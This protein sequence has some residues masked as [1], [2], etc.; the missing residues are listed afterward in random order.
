METRYGKPPEKP[1]DACCV[2]APPGW[3]CHCRRAAKRATSEPNGVPRS[4]R[5]QKQRTSDEGATT[6]RALGPEESG[7]QPVTLERRPEVPRE[8]A[9][10]AA[11][12]RPVVQNG[13]SAVST[14]VKPSRRYALT[15]LL[16]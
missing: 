3:M 14:R 2:D 9:R 15:S 12:G 10:R 13:M 6:K 7:L 5:D 16:S 1:L 8:S 11:P 4:C